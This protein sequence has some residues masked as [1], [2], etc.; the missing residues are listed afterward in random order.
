MYLNILPK[1]IIQNT[2]LYLQPEELDLYYHNPEYKSYFDCYFWKKMKDKLKV[3]EEI[4][5]DY[6]GYLL[7]LSWSNIYLSESLFIDCFNDV[8]YGLIRRKNWIL[9]EKLIN[10]KIRGDKSIGQSCL[11]RL[12]WCK[13]INILLKLQTIDSFVFR[14]YQLFEA[15]KDIVIK[16]NKIYFTNVDIS[17]LC[18][19][20]QVKWL[21]K[22]I[23]IYNDENIIPRIIWSQMT[24]DQRL[25]FLRS[26]FKSQYQTYFK[27]FTELDDKHF[28]S[29]T[30]DKFLLLSDIET[31][32]KEAKSE[33]EKFISSQNY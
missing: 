33:Y 11:Y 5:L 1:E 21:Q 26:S 7:A 16:N 24:E 25:S 13:Q 28:K 3:T 2:L 32:K 9:L 20:G 30:V 23:H 27:Y 10:N 4:D 12:L 15:L 8:C 19:K 6:K 14:A 22:L 29:Y 31:E 17:C 18:K